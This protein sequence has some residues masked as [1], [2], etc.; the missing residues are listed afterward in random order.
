MVLTKEKVTKQLRKDR[1][2]GVEI[3]QCEVGN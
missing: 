3:G 2:S 1:F